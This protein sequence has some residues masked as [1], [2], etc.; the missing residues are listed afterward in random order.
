M[1]ACLGIIQMLSGGIDGQQSQESG[2]GCGL[3]VTNLHQ[4]VVVLGAG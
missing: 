3:A 2:Q 1:S 4:A